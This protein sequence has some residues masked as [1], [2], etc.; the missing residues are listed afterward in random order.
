MPTD[1]DM[2]GRPQALLDVSTSETLAAWMAE[3]PEALIG[4][5]TPTGAPTAIPPSI[6]LG[7]DHQTDE[8]SLLDL[9]VPED[10]KAVADA[11]VSALTRG[12]GIT[13][14]HMASEP[15]LPLLLRYLD[16]RET[17][18]VLIR[19]VVAGGAHGQP[20]RSFRASNLAPTRPRLG[21]MTKDE[22]AKV[23]SIDTALSLMLGWAETDMVGHQNLEFIHP[24]DHIRAIDN[25]M[26]RTN[27]DHV[28]TVQTVR[29]RYLCKDGSWL[30]LETSNESH[31][32]ADGTTVV[33]ARLFDVSEEMAA[34]EALR[35]N[36]SFLRRVTDTVPV[37]LFHIGSDGAVAFVNPVLQDLLGDRV[38]RSMAE[39]ADALLSGQGALLRGAIEDVMAGGIDADLDVALAE[40]DLRTR[41]VCRVNLR[42][43][44]DDGNVLGVLG[45]VVDVTELRSM[46]DTDVLTGLQNRRSIMESLASNLVSHR[47]RVAAI[48]LDLDHFKPINDQYGHHVG[49]QLLSAVAERLRERVRSTDQAGRHGGDEFLIVCPGIS[50]QKAAV[51]LARR[52]QSI[53]KEP[54]LLSGVSVAMTASLGVAC[55][56]PDVTADQLVSCADTAM[57]DAKRTRGGPPVFRELLES[58]AAST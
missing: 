41:S 13:K 25:W 58:A 47:G 2:Q 48:Y 32:E 17:H 14:I 23:L 51:S 3:S 9:V 7:A 53:F 43:I 19:L 54:F 22:V 49:D 57:Y 28:S 35:H 44:T 46:A 27:A 42:A 33:V 4:A 52:V 8:R 10:T 36:E 15:T 20:E 1:S 38:V 56:T 29:L 40:H 11:F 6:A 37:G 34:V 39:L 12:I 5:V 26:S 55:G 45:C 21:V 30:W 50:G 24:D 31:L 16:L 18:G